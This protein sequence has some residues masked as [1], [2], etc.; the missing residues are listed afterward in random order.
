MYCIVKKVM[1]GTTV[2]VRWFY[3]GPY[4]APMSFE[5][6]LGPQE[7]LTFRKGRIGRS[8]AKL[9]TCSHQKNWEDWWAADGKM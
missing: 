8:R 2:S 1:Q 7:K 9:N 3:A 6:M 5:A 4:V